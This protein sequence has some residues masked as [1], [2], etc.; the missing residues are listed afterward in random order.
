MFL[1]TINDTKQCKLV[2]DLIDV[3]SSD[4]YCAIIQEKKEKKE[5]AFMITNNFCNVLDTKLCPIKP[6]FYA[7]NNEFIVISDNNYVYVL[8]YKGYYKSKKDKK[9][10]IINLIIIKLMK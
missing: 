9:K 10:I 4:F 7:M 6:L 5:Y 3:M 2:Y 1:N 8:Q